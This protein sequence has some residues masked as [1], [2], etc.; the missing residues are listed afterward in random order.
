MALT[1]LVQMWRG[2]AW[3]IWS[4]VVMSGRHTQGAVQFQS[5]FLYYQSKSW[6]W[7][8][9]VVLLAD[10]VNNHVWVAMPCSCCVICL[11]MLHSQWDVCGGH[12]IMHTMMTLFGIMAFVYISHGGNWDQHEGYVPLKWKT[13]IQ[14]GRVEVWGN[15][16]TLSKE[17]KRNFYSLLNVMTS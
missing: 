4:H 15:P 1:S 17:W 3:E 14:C 16:P 9:K 5:P 6:R 10:E 7:R 12:L 11:A 13:P 8:Q 2:K